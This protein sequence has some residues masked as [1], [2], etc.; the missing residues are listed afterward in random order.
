MTVLINGSDEYVDSFSDM[1]EYYSVRTVE[2]EVE[3]P[4]Q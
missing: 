4:V 1:D 2:F 3:N